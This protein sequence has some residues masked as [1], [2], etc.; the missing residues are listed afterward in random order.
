M[1]TLSD[2]PGRLLLLL[3]SL[4][5]LSPSSPTFP[6]LKLD[7]WEP[8]EIAFIC[9][10]WLP[11]EFGHNKTKKTLG[12][13]RL[14]GKCLLS[15]LFTSFSGSL[16]S[17]SINTQAPLSAPG[18]LRAHLLHRVWECQSRAHLP[19]SVQQQDTN[20]Y[21]PVGGLLVPWAWS[22]LDRNKVSFPGEERPPFNKKSRGLSNWLGLQSQKTQAQMS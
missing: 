11:H 4:I 10:L 14:E 19:T 15:I 22:W 9:S 18:L 17:L 12:R 13:N 1:A 8:T 3:H 7:W 5:T 16:F 20:S 21:S 2:F 6:I